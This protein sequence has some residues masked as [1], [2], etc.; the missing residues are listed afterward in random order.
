MKKIRRHDIVTLEN[1]EEGKVLN[2]VII[3]G[4]RILEIEITASKQIEYV[5]ESKLT[6]KK[7]WF[8]NLLADKL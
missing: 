8:W 1:G 3:S 2:E 7:Q 4:V 5:I 6:L